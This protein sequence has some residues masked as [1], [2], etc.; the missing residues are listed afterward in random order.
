MCLVRVPIPFRRFRTSRVGGD[1]LSGTTLCS[2]AASLPE[3]AG[4]Q[5]I[6][7]PPEDHVALSARMSQELAD[8]PQWLAV[9]GVLLWFAP[10]YSIH[11]G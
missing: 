3:V 4:R 10:C 11:L 2:D 9:A 8:D 1:G 5:D 6:L 7:F